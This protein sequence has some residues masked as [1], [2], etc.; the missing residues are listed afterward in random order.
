MLSHRR[1]LILVL[2]PIPI[3]IASLALT[4]WA[5][6][7]ADFVVMQNQVL[8][9]EPRAAERSNA[10]SD[11]ALA[12][13]RLENE[14]RQVAAALG[15]RLGDDCQV[16]V[17]EPFV[18]A[19]DLSV[20]ALDHWHRNTIDPAVRAMQRAY[21]STAPD[22]P[23]TLLLFDG[24]ASYEGHARRLYG[25][26]GISVFGYY[27]PDERVLVTNIRTGG[28]TLVH[29]L[30]HALVDFDFRDVPD[31]FNEGLASMHEQCRIRDDGS[32][33]DGLVN[34]RLPLLQQALQQGRLRPLESLI[35]DGDFR[36]SDVELNY[37][38]AR[39]LCLWL[40]EQSR[41]ADFYRDFRQGHA[42]DPMGYAALWRQFP[43][44][45]WEQIDAAFRGWVAQL[46]WS[47]SPSDA[48]TRRVATD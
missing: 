15:D 32:G 18:I 42:D 9:N 34:W 23:V 12:D 3:V 7:D 48:S 13:E 26:E 14:C 22:R 40:Q 47:A 25:E 6:S 31:W 1:L 10:L 4:R 20:E 29:E 44:R 38:Q 36:E 8:I 33:I 39:Y 24:I 27:K 35:L 17:R 45:S 2:G 43:E 41:L 46:E 21:F 11:A 28:G 5:R 16:I 30:T 37:A 19:G